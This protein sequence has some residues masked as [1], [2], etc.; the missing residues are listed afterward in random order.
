MV[1]ELFLKLQRCLVH[2]QKDC[3]IW[4]TKNPKSNA[5]FDLKRI[6]SKLHKINRHYE[7]GLWLMEVQKWEEN[8]KDYI[9]QKSY[10]PETERYWY[11]HK[12]VR[13]FFMAIRRA[14]P[15]MLHYLDSPNIPK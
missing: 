1:T 14:L 7:L 8:Y 9:N 2:Q 4:L 11:T 10:N 13:W 3:R 12:M 6:S 5:G 15:N